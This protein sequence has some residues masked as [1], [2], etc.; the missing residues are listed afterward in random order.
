MDANLTN[1]LGDEYSIGS[2]DLE[3]SPKEIIKEFAENHREEAA[4]FVGGKDE[5]DKL[6]GSNYAFDSTRSTIALI[7]SDSEAIP[8]EWEKPLN[9]QDKTVLAVLKNAK[10]IVL[11]VA[12]S[13][14]NAA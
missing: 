7:V 14:P 9:Q 8:L 1:I 6:I 3:N 4:S 12:I 13:M 11:N 10:E 2:V 5:L